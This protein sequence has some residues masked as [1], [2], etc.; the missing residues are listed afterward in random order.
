VRAALGYALRRTSARIVLALALGGLVW[1][2]FRVARPPYH[3]E[4][5]GLRVGPAHLPILGSSPWA[6]AVATLVVV[7]AAMA[8]AA[9]YRERSTS[10]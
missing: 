1:T 6:T 9:L 7:V 10:R 4:V 8:G 5:G 2:V 3:P